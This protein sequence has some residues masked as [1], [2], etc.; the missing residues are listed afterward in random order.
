MYKKKITLITCE[1]VSIFDGDL[2][3]RSAPSGRPS[4]LE[5]Y[6]EPDPFYSEEFSEHEQ[7]FNNGI[8]EITVRIFE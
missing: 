6:F 3:A 2:R 1:L 8:R 7:E 5:P 4:V